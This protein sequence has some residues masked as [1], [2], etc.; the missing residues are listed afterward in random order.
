MTD[1][2]RPTNMTAL[3]LAPS[4]IN[5]IPRS[6]STPPPPRYTRRRCLPLDT[7]IEVDEDDG[8]IAEMRD[9]AGGT[10]VAST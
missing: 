3:S 9:R 10:R 2:R 7:D 4:D 5:I 1:D 8:V 6:V